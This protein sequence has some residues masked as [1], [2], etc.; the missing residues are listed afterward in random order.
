MDFQPTTIESGERRWADAFAVLLLIL[1]L[2]FFPILWPLYFVRRRYHLRSRGYWVVRQGRDAIEYQEMHDGKVERLI[3]GGEM[4]VGA[5]HVVYVPTAE[6]WQQTMPEW[7]QGRR[8]EII[9]N[10][11]G[12][13]G[14]KNYE[15]DYS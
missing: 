12:K 8:E 9:E 11:K 14:T 7:A 13:L 4:L 15:Y 10:V 3:I 5:P 2:V 6:E 1:S